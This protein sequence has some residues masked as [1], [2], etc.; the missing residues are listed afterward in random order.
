[1]T[2]DPDLV[3]HEP[4]RP[5]LERALP[6]YAQVVEGSCL[7]RE[8]SALP[9]RAEAGCSTG[10]LAEGEYHLHRLDGREH[11]PVGDRP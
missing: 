5:V 8:L 1:M 10:A 6:T 9:A 7:Q 2:L 4:C 11:E 3:A